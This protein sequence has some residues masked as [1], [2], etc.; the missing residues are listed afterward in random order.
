MN[1]TLASLL[2]Q[3]KTF[4]ND[5]PRCFFALLALAAVVAIA[6]ICIIVSLCTAPPTSAEILATLPQSVRFNTWKTCTLSVAE[7]PTAQAPALQVLL[8]ELPQQAPNDTR[9]SAIRHV[10]AGDYF[11]LVCGVLPSPTPILG[12]SPT[13]PD[14]IQQTLQQEKLTKVGEALQ[15]LVHEEIGA[16][17]IAGKQLVLEQPLAATSCTYRGAASVF[18]KGQ[19]KG[20]DAALTVNGRIFIFNHVAYYL[21]TLHDAAIDETGETFVQH[22]L[23]SIRFLTTEPTP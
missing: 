13:Q 20:G 8:P 12:T 7:T 14:V 1:S 15:T 19:A 21:Y 11:T 10:Y 3:L 6:V 17:V 22:A 23:N 18:L 16:S 4:R 2:Q 9:D 5:Q